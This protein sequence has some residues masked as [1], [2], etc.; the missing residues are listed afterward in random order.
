[1]LEPAAGLGDHVEEEIVRVV[2]AAAHD[3]A[4]GFDDLLHIDDGAVGVEER[5]VAF[6]HQVMAF[7][8][9]L[10]LADDRVA[11]NDRAVNERVEVFRAVTV[12]H[13]A[14]HQRRRGGPP[15]RR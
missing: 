6:E 2:V 14:S 9:D 13:G 5:R 10:E 4:A 15:R 1:M 12:R 3:G 11:E 7:V 8:R